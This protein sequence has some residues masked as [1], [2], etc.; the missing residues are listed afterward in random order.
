M[1]S[2]AS[3]EN[4]ENI[5]APVNDN[6]SFGYIPGSGTKCYEESDN[7]S[8]VKGIR[9][10]FSFNKRKK[11]QPTGPAEHE[12]CFGD[13][14][15]AR[16]VMH[17]KTILEFMMNSIND[18]TELWGELRRKCR[19]ICG[20]AKLYLRNASRGW[21]LER[22][23][24]IYPESRR[25]KMKRDTGENVACSTYTVVTPPHIDSDHISEAFRGEARQLTFPWDL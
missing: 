4:S 22:P 18:L 9:R 5:F 8:G 11:A 1:K 13:R 10:S 24:M 15:F 12:I 19:G 20:L 23:L 14:L 16:L 17:G 3:I 21:S 2:S 25:R 7:R 6:P